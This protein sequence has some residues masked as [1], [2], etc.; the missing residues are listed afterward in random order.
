MHS[1]PTPRQAS[2]TPSTASTACAWAA[3]TAP[4]SSCRR[5]GCGLPSCWEPGWPPSG[6]GLGYAEVMAG[7]L[8][9]PGRRLSGDAPPP[10]A[11]DPDRGGG[12]DWALL[13]VAG[14]AVV[15]HLIWGRLAAEGI[16]VHLDAS[17][18]SP[19]A[20]LHPFGDPA[21]PVK[22]FVRRSDLAAASLLLHEVDD[23]PS[24]E[25]DIETAPVPGGAAGAEGPSWT[26]F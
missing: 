23:A 1:T 5:G 17:N 2:A 4:T 11:H 24:L 10:P 26:G 14:N 22:V 20:W 15:A 8:T 3:S 16:D 21:S 18:P 9:E 6:R 25:P 19:A 13:T 7:V 12:G